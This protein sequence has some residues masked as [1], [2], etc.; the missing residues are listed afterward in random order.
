MKDLWN[1]VLEN[2]KDEEVFSGFGFWVDKEQNVFED[3]K[4]LANNFART[5]EKSKGEINWDYGLIKSLPTLAEQA[6]EETLRILKSYLLDHFLS[7]PDSFHGSVF[8]DDFVSAFEILYRN[9]ATKSATYNLI[10]EL[11]LKG[12]SRFW[13][14][15]EVLGNNKN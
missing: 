11:I 4:W 9:I 7:K 5:L 14:L 1:W 2:I 10:N 6:P 3:S 15:K 12:S 13:K 8:I